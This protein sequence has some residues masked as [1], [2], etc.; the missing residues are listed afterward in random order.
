MIYIDGLGEPGSRSHPG[1]DEL[2]D[3]LVETCTGEV[4]TEYVGTEFDRSEFDVIPIFTELELS[5]VFGHVHT[6]CVIDTYEPVLGSVAGS[7]R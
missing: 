7:N 1:D 5:K 6:G 4:F 2:Y 3:E